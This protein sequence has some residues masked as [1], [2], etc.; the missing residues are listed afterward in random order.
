MTTVASSTELLTAL[1]LIEQRAD[2][3]DY[4]MDGRFGESIDRFQNQVLSSVEP[5]LITL[6]AS[7]IELRFDA[8]GLP[9]V[10]YRLILTG[11]GIGPISSLEALDQAIQDGLATGRL[12]AI[13]LTANGATHLA[14]ALAPGGYTLTTGVDV[15]ALNGAMPTTFAE[16]AELVSLLDQFDEVAL[17]SDTPA[18]RAAYFAD[19]AQYGVT[20]FSVRTDGTTL[21]ALAITATGATLTVDD[22]TM[23]L[24]GT[25]PDDFGAIASTLFDAFTL[26][27]QTGNPLNLAQLAGFGV[28]SFVITNA[29][30]TELLRMTGPI[31]TVGDIDMHT[32]TGTAGND[33]ADL[34]QL[35]FGEA[36]AVVVNLLA[37]DDSATLNTYDLY[38]MGR[39]DG[40][41][42][43]DLPQITLNGGTG[44][45]TLIL[46][47]YAYQSGVEIDL[48][49]GQIYGYDLANPLPDVYRATAIGFQQLVLEGQGITVYGSGANETVRLS[50]GY[51]GPW[52]E[53]E[54]GAG[55][56]TLDLSGADQSDGNY[57]FGGISQADLANFDVSINA[58]N[59][60]IALMYAGGGNSP[61]L[62]LEDV[63]FL[64]VQ[65]NGNP[66]AMTNVA[67]SS[68][69]TTTFVMDGS[70]TSYAGSYLNDVIVGTAAGDEIRGH[71]GNDLIAGNAGN[72]SLYGGDGADT[73]NG[74]TGDDFIFGGATNADLRDV[75]YGGDGND[76]IDG[77]AGN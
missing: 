46:Q 38:Q 45:N 32:V 2:N 42:V 64:R 55:S 31:T 17:T 18:E 41:P 43:A 63:E 50:S 1:N 7:R 48:A 77:G 34:N 39:Y 33:V 70:S 62:Y 26:F 61:D 29:G 8:P 28:D 16:M 66:A 22:V 44:V 9:A 74:G 20:G 37:G 69:V 65:Q 59:G 15:Y 57:Y 58:A 13:S 51:W 23:T 40:V 76:S 11:V 67:V 71:N 12:N 10:D 21:A 5:V 24:T 3:G 54:G 75:V 36:D 19:L 60:Q 25:L 49:D 68:L 4:E 35:P 52:V 73:L 56:D 30:G 53:F 27:E 6:T 47:N 72:D 14:L